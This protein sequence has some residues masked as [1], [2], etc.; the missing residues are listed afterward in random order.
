MKRQHCGLGIEERLLSVRAERRSR[1]D[2]G[3]GGKNGVR[4]PG[5]VRPGAAEPPSHGGHADLDVMLGHAV[6]LRSIGAVGNETRRADG[7]SGPDGN[8]LGRG[9]V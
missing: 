8:L 7:G 3:S 2:R 5:M 6:S 4:Q 9:R 1:L